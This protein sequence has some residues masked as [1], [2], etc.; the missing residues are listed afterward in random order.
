MKNKELISN[1]LE[2]LRNDLNNI[3]YITNT[4]GNFQELERAYSIAFNTLED[5]TG[6]ISIESDDFRSHQII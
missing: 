2:K 4:S 6:I 1:K 5:I 3:K